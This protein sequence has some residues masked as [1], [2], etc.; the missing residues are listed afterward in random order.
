M[1]RQLTTLPQINIETD[2][3]AIKDT[4]LVSLTGVRVQQKLS[5]PALCELTF[6]DADGL[7]NPQDFL[8]GSALKV[9]KLT[10]LMT[11]FS[12]VRSRRLNIYTNRRE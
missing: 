6:H 1:N 12:M 4:A 2:G 9:A 7:I 8:I 3:S 11:R 5:L 10:V